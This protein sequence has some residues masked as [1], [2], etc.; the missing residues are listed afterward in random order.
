M[1]KK[2]DV[3]LPYSKFKHNLARILESEGLLKSVDV[4]EE[5]GLKTLVLGMKYGDGGEPAISG[6]KRVSKPGQRIYSNNKE[7]PRSL[8]GAGITIVSTSKGLMTDK[9]ARKQHIGGEIVCQ[10]W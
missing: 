1:V 4:K 5:T 10:I 2:P 9:T 6:L 7:I 3:S 8:G